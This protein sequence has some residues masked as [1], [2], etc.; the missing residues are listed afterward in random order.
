VLAEIHDFLTQEKVR[1]RKNA[2]G[3]AS[4]RTLNST[5]V[6]GIA[7]FVLGVEKANSSA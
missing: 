5:N 4:S 7:P 6:Q 3:S 2:T 1:K